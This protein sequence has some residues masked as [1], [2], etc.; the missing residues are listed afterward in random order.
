MSPIANEAPANPRR[1]LVLALVATGA[2]LGTL[3]I[4]MLIVALP[5]LTSVFNTTITVSQWF[6]L[7]DALVNTS[8][9]LTAG[10]AFDVHGRRRVYS[11]GLLTFGVGAL[12]SGLAVSGSM[13][14]VTRAVQGAGSAAMIAG[15]P[16]LLTAAFPSYE[17]SKVLGFSGIGVAL[18]VLAGSLLGG[19]LV[20]Y[21]GWRWIF[22]VVAPAALGASWVL[23]TRVDGLNETCCGRI[24]RA[25]A[26]LVAASLTALLLGLTHGQ[27]RGWMS[28]WTFAILAAG[29]VL[30]AGFIVVE[31]RVRDPILDLSM[32]ASKEVAIG[33]LSAAANYAAIIPMAVF[34]PFY[35]QNVLGYNADQVGFV[36][37]SGPVGLILV[38]PIAAVRFERVGVRLLTTVGLAL[39]GVAALLMRTLTEA[40]EWPCV[41]WRV[42]LVGAGA[43]LFVAPNSSRVFRSVGRDRI[44]AA[45]GILSFMRE[46]GMVLGIGVSAAILATVARGFSLTAELAG[47]VRATE[48]GFLAGSGD[49]YLA[50]AAVAFAGAVLSAFRGRNMAS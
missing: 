21:V 31:K 2:F 34:T 6:L 46:M 37:A 3:D 12:A 18:G 5:T 33:M 19:I 32:F 23:S 11:F 30:A 41:V 38:A 14:I 1:W 44:G 40:S 8:L 27:S 13:L 17:R 48:H 45:N 50:A 36:L 49:A 22:L 4:S 35:V 16:A 20:H 28:A 43:G 47:D 7:S 26:L 10:K 24:D 42:A 25:G 9:L 29:L 15:G 39:V